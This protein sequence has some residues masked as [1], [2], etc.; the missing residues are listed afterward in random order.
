MSY[1]RDI[2]VNRQNGSPIDSEQIPLQ[3][4]LVYN[5]FT[6]ANEQTSEKSYFRNGNEH[7]NSIYFTYHRSNQSW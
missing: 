5:S 3:I 6:D 4:E 7:F 1:S 2:R